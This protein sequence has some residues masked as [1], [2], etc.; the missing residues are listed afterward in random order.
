[1]V[2]HIAVVLPTLWLVLKAVCG[3]STARRVVL[4]VDLLLRRWWWVWWQGWVLAG[5]ARTGPAATLSVG[6]PW[7]RLH[8]TVW[9]DGS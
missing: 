2:Y 5:V 4:L 6:S 3:H 7:L 9:F 8:D 1:M